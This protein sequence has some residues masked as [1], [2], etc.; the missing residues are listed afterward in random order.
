MRKNLTTVALLALSVSFSQL[1]FAGQPGDG[2]FKVAQAGSCQSMFRTCA[3]RC[4]E[5]APQ[6]KNC[7]SDHCSP[8]LSECRQTGCWQEG[9]L[10]G[11]GKQCG[12]AK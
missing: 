6:D 1:A 5:R 7:V 10:Y 2:S 4:R 8:K 3:A 9:A 12:L 11:G